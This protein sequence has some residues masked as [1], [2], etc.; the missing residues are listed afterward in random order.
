MK[1]V[2]VIKSGFGE[3]LPDNYKDEILL[4]DTFEEFEAKLK[5]IGI[6]EYKLDDVEELYDLLYKDGRCY[7]FPD[8]VSRKNKRKWN[9]FKK[10]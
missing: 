6:T 9:I 1:T 5:E 3:N 10:K 2:F 7:W 8:G 4:F